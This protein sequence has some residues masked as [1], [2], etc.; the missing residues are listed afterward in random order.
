M[1]RVRGGGADSGSAPTPAPSPLQPPSTLI[2]GFKPPAVFRRGGLP[3]V[4]HQH[5][6]FGGADGPCSSTH[7]IDSAR[8]SIVRQKKSSTKMDFLGELDQDQENTSFTSY[9]ERGEVV[10]PVVTLRQIRNRKCETVSLRLSICPNSVYLLS[11]ILRSGLDG[12]SHFHH[13]THHKWR[14]K[15]TIFFSKKFR[16]G[17]GGSCPIQ[18][19]LIRKN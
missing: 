4:R 11:T 14:H 13:H 5:H 9:H 18:N 6:T 10:C 15:K 12:F 7:I 1:R 2:Q 16:K 19:F 8:I 17:G 3:A